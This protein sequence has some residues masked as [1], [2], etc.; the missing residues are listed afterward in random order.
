MESQK[1]QP[2]VLDSEALKQLGDEIKREIRDSLK[3]S[4]LS[5]VLE[6][7][8]ISRDDVLEIQCSIDPTKLPGGDTNHSLLIP[9]KH[10]VLLDCWCAGHI[11]DCPCPKP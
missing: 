9:G 4:N 3:N 8:N 6:K 7:Y 2:K 1:A 5:K 11:D 10:I